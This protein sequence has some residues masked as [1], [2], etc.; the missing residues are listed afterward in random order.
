MVTTLEARS[1]EKLRVFVTDRSGNSPLLVAA[2]QMHAARLLEAAGVATSWKLCDASSLLPGSEPCFESR[3]LSVAVRVLPAKEAKA[4]PIES[5]SCGLALA[6]AQSEHGIL[7]IVDA[8]C[9]RRIAGSTPQR[10]VAALG[11][12]IA[13]EIGHLLLGRASHSPSGLMSAR[14]TGDELRLLVRGELLFAEE[15]AARLQAAVF[16]RAGAR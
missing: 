3:P 11:H 4:W 9:I 14:W 8:D 15:D 1:R 6:G 10:W 2:A 13:H 12:V 16:A 7:A 5:L